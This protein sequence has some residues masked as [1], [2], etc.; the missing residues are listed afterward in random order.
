MKNVRD[1]FPA[2]FVNR[3]E[4]FIPDFDEFL[5]AMLTP[6][7]KVFRVNTIKANPEQVIP[8]VADLKPKPL[9]YLPGAYVAEE[10]AGLGK[11]LV[12]FLGLIYIQEAASMVPPLLL[13][14]RP[15]ERVLDLAAAP[16]SKTT[17]MAA[18]MK[19]QGLLIAN[20]LSFHRLRGLIG[21]IDRMGC[22]NVVV[23]RADGVVLARQLAGTCDRV[24]VDAPCS[25]EGT[26]RKTREALRRWSLRGIENFSRVQKGLITAGYQ[27]LKPGGLM[28]Y[29]TC[30]IAPEENEVVVAYLMK[31]FPEAEILP[32][33]LENFRM[34]PALTEW[35]GNIFPPALERCRRILPQDNN[36]EAFFVAL[37]RKP[38]DITS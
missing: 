13:G 8:L 36:T 32:V 30:T 29:S 1:L 25:S 15:G 3:Y 33:T 10:G 23:C 20:D 38:D 37:I 11:T 34:R 26:I 21:N 4:K 19:N 16:G 14:P 22:L 6:L 18:M 12:H 17:Q 7:P 2:D 5:T 28:V 24:L 9:P 35:E 27:A 31:R